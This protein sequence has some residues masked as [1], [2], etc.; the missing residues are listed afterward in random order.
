MTT[1]SY[2]LV[3][4]NFTRAELECKCKAIHLDAPSLDNLALRLQVLRTSFGRALNVNSAYRCKDHN[5]RSGGVK[6]SKHV[7]GQAADISTVGWTSE[8]RSRFIRLAT[9]LGFGGIGIN[10]K[11]Q[12][13]HIDLRSVGMLWLYKEAKTGD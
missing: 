1:N 7:L 8:D 6:D 3:L 5:S 13:I 4:D 12:Y 11:Q 10:N 9:G 2:S